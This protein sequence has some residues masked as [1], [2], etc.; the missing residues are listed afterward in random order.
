[1]TPRSFDIFC[2]VIDNYGD[3]G[4][5]WRLARQ[6][7]QPPYSARVRL[8]VDN[9]VRC[10]AL[11]PGVLPDAMQQRCHGVD[12]RRWDATAN[13]HTLAEDP[14]VTPAQVV[15]E[16]FACDPPAAF[17][18]AMTPQTLWINLEYLS[19]QAWV[20]GCHGLPSPQAGGLTKWFFF[21][22]F[23]AQTGGLLREP[24]LLARRDAWQ[25]DPHKRVALLQSLRL[26]QTALR[27]LQHREANTRQ[28]LLFCYPHAPVA[29]LLQGLMQDARPT[30]VLAS[31]GTVNAAHKAMVRDSHVQI[32][33][34]AFVAQASFDALL[35][36]SDLNCVRG[37]DSLVRA[38]WAGRPLLWHIY[39]QTQNAHLEK[40]DAWLALA[41]YPAHIA[42]LIRRWNAQT[43]DG[44]FPSAASGDLAR[45]VA[46]S[47]APENYTDWWTKARAWAQSLAQQDDLASALMRFSCERMKKQANAHWS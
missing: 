30:V 11:V 17:V 6:L 44:A 13:R 5:C 15:I 10:R 19:A 43:A 33:D 20:Q 34:I 28:V 38:L 42:D 18:R 31:P 7:V 26:P 16:A 21:P 22:G 32:C 46:T 25:A 29:A 37:E 4:V 45:A 2:R 35:W 41:P 24:D 8:W 23:T 39:P 12:I 1:V 14:A 47:L 27:M 9:L 40:L 3:I 36:G